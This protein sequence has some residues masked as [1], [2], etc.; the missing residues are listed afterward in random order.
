MYSANREG[1]SKHIYALQ[2][3]ST[4]FLL[5]RMYVC[6]ILRTCLMLGCMRADASVFS[7]TVKDVYHLKKVI[8]F[9]LVCCVNI[10]TQKELFCVIAC[11]AKDDTYTMCRDFVELYGVI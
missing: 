7:A 4:V 11:A 3:S 9:R 5:C 10:L 6:K 2:Y 1:Y 8:S